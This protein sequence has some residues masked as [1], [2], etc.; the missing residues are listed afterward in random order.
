MQSVY[1]TDMLK[2][3]KLSV[4]LKGT[5]AVPCLEFDPATLVIWEIF[6]NRQI[7]LDEN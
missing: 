1:T 2:W 6:P 3:F 4:L 7:K 5:I